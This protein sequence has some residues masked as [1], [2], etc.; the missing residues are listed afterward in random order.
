MAGTSDSVKIIKNLSQLD[1]IEIIAT[2]TTKY[3]GELASDAGADEI[4]VGHLGIQEISD[5]LDVN[6]IEVLIDATHPFAAEATVNA[7]RS[8]NKSNTKYIRF[9]RPPTKIPDN[10][11]LFEAKS[12]EEASKMAV[13]LIEGDKRIMH[14]A[15]V[16]TLPHI[17]QW[18]SPKKI[19]ARVLPVISSIKKSLELGIPVKNI[20]AMQ[21]TFSKEFNTI[22]FKEFKIGLVITKESGETGGTKSK[23]DA[24]MDLNI[25]TIIVKRPVID[26][27]ENEIVFTNT[28]DLI[29][30]IRELF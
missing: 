18:N 24:A 2:T 9:E 20:I 8:A 16:S 23:L 3:G 28:D 25:P 7:I 17:L 27:L 6:K 29:K 26:E 12:F 15:G 10:K 30:N 4:I 13:E 14:L 1:E 21:G 19:V 22:L 5:L 11:L